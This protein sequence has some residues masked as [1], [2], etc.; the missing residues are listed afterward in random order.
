MYALEKILDCLRIKIWASL[1]N[2][3]SI[4]RTWRVVN[5]NDSKMQGCMYTKCHIKDK[6]FMIEDNID[7]GLI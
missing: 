6:L 5:Q 7:C 1:M 4:S 3:T 2:I